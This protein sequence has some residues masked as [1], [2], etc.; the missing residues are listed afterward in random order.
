MPFILVREL[1]CPPIPLPCDN[2]LDDFNPVLS[3]RSFRPLPF[4]YVGSALADGAF[5]EV[6]ED[7]GT[8]ET[9]G[10]DVLLPLLP[11]STLHSRPFFDDPPPLPLAALSPPE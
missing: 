10:D 11:S 5:D 6:G 7:V 8:N 3:L 2:F 4:P 1:P 9:D